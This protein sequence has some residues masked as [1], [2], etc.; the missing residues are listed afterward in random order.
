[1]KY[2]LE[3]IGSALDNHIA[4]QHKWEAEMSQ[5][6]DLLKSKLITGNGETALV[7]QMHIANNWIAGANKLLWLVIASIVGQMVLVTL[8]LIA[9]FLSGR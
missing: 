1:M 9:M 8:G 3:S 6:V 4:V 7:E 5:D 2:T